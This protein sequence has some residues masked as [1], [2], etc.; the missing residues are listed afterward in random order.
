MGRTTPEQRKLIVEAVKR[1]VH[2]NVVAQVFNTT[3][4]TVTEWCRRVHYIL[5][6]PWALAQRCPVPP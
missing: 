5:R 6:I 2:K 4:K 1:G 3:V